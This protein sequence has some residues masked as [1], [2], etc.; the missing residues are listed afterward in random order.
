MD[1]D[2]GMHVSIRSSRAATREVVSL[3]HVGEYRSYLTLYYQRVIDVNLFPRPS[4]NIFA[5]GFVFSF[6]SDVLDLDPRGRLCMCASIPTYVG[7]VVCLCLCACACVC[8]CGF[9]W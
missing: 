4:P 7:V 9:L 6:A 2:W 1:D 3:F 5:S 8:V